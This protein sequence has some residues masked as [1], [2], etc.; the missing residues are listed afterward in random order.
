MGDQCIERTS[1]M[2]CKHAMAS[3]APA[4]PSECPSMLFVL[5]SFIVSLVLTAPKTSL[6]AAT[7]HKSPTG[8]D[9]PCA[10][11]KSTSFASIPASL[12]AV[13][14][15]RITS[16]PSARGDVRSYAS[17]EIPPP[18]YSARIG[19][20]RA[21]ACA[22]DSITS[23]PRALRVEGPYEATSGWSS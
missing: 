7:S 16:R 14:M 4:A 1:A 17:V 22:N 23:T 6:I 5:F 10:L 18:R 12:S 11:T 20:P 8:V 2:D 15:H 13:R 19:A 9:V 3:N 21:F